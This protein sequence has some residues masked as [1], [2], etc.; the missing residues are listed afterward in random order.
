MKNSAA[1]PEKTKNIFTLSKRGATEN[2]REF[3]GRNKRQMNGY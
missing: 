2:S 1:T 3:H